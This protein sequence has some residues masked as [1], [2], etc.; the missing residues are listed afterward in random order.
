M[1]AD[2]ATADC[3]VIHMPLYMYTCNDLSG[4]FSGTFGG[5]NNLYVTLFIIKLI[6]LSTYNVE[7]YMYTFVYSH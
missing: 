4:F 5:F 7:I 2:E 6:I 1:V 3:L